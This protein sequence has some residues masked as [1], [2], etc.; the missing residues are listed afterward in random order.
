MVGSLPACCARAASGH[1]AA[2]PRSVTWAV[3]RLRAAITGV[4]IGHDHV[5]L[6]CDQL[7]R[8]AGDT[9]GIAVAQR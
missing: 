1:A 8:M 6:R 5:G 4:L 7:R 9:V 3:A 2:P